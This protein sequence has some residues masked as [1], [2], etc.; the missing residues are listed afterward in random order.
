M[1]KS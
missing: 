1:L